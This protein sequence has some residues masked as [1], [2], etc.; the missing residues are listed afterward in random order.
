MRGFASGG[1]DAGSQ[2]SGVLSGV[3]QERRLVVR[4]SFFEDLAVRNSPGE[5]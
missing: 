1:K 5:L 2:F 4:L 3:S